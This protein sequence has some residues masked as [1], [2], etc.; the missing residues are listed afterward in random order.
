MSKDLTADSIA[1][2]MVVAMAQEKIE[3]ARALDANAL[4]LVKSWKD[5]RDSM[6]PRSASATEIVDLIRRTIEWIVN[7]NARPASRNAA[8]A[9]FLTA[10]SHS[11]TNAMLQGIQ[12]PEEIAAIRAAATAGKWL[13]R[14]LD[15]VGVKPSI[16]WMILPRSEEMMSAWWEA[17]Q[18]VVGLLYAKMLN[19]A[20]PE[21]PGALAADERQEVLAGIASHTT[22]IVD[23]LIIETLCDTLR[24][25]T[26]GLTLIT[27]LEE[28]GEADKPSLHELLGSSTVRWPK[29]SNASKAAGVPKKY[30][31][32]AAMTLRD[33][34]GYD[35]LPSRTVV[36]SRSALPAAR[37]S[38]ITAVFDTGATRSFVSPNVYDRLPGS[39]E[40]VAERRCPPLSRVALANGIVQLP[41]PISARWLHVRAAPDHPLVRVPVYVLDGAPVEV[42]FGV[43]AMSL[44]G[45][46][47]VHIE[48]D[49]SHSVELKLKPTSPAA[50]T[51]ATS[52]AVAPASVPPSP[53][54]VATP[55]PQPAPH[56]D[57]SEEELVG[58]AHGAPALFLFD[59]VD[60][61][62]V[63]IEAHGSEIYGPD[64]T[65]QISPEQ[66][67]A[68]HAIA[69]AAA[70]TPIR[71]GAAQ[72]QAI[73]AMLQPPVLAM[74]RPD[75]THPGRD[76]V[77][78]HNAP[79]Q[80][81]APPPTYKY[82]S[83]AEAFMDR[84]NQTDMPAPLR[85]RIAHEVTNVIKPTFISKDAPPQP[86]GPFRGA[87]FSL[88]VRRGTHLKGVDDS[89][90]P[91]SKE[92]YDFL[93]AQAETWVKLGVLEP[94]A[95]GET[96]VV[97]QPVV[98]AKRGKDDTVTGF[99]AAFDFRK[100]N[101]VL[102]QDKL[103]PEPVRKIAELAARAWRVTSLDATALFNQFELE[104]ESRYLTTVM[105]RPGAYFRFT[106]APF[107][108]SSILGFAQHALDEYIRQGDD[109]CRVYVDDIFL[110]H[111]L[112]GG[113]DIAAEQL[114]RVLRRCADRNL[115]LNADKA[116]LFQVKSIIVGHEVD[117]ETHTFRPRPARM[118]MLAE[119]P[120]PTT[121]RKLRRFLAMASAWARFLPGW[122]LH[123]PVLSRFAGTHRNG[124]L[125]WTAEADAVF[126]KLKQWIVEAARSREWDPTKQAF[127]YTDGCAT[128][129]AWAVTQEDD[130]GNQLLIDCGGRKTASH[131]R[132]LFPHE[133]EVLACREA[134]REAPLYI[135]RTP[136]PTIWRTDSRAAVML[137]QQKTA[138]KSNAVRR[139]LLEMQFGAL[140]EIRAEHIA[141]KSN[142]VDAL[143]RVYE[144]DDDHDAFAALR[145]RNTAP[146]V[147]M[148]GTVPSMDD[149]DVDGE[150]GELAESEVDD[151]D[152]V[153]TGT[154]E[155]A[156]ED[157]APA[158]P[159]LEA[160]SSDA[161]PVT[162]EDDET[163]SRRA[164]AVPVH[165]A[166]AE[167]VELTRREED[168]F[169]E[170]VACDA[171]LGAAWRD[172][173]R[174]WGLATV[175]DEAALT[176][177]LAKASREEYV[178]AA[179]VRRL[180]AMRDEYGRVFVH[181]GG[182][183]KL[184][185]PTSMLEPLVAA[186]HQALG[187]RAAD[188]VLRHLRQRFFSPALAD[189]AK[190]TCEACVTC[191]QLRARAPDGIV[192]RDDRF[193]GRFEHVHLDVAEF[194][195]EQRYCLVVVDRV[196]GAVEVAPMTTR[197]AAEVAEAFERIWL[198]R[199][200]A[201]LV[202]S[203]DNAAELVGDTMRELGVRCG[204]AIDPVAPRNPQANGVVE[205]AVRG[206][207]RAIRAL[208]PLGGDW[209]AVLPKA[210]WSMVAAV[211]TTRGVSPLMLTTG[212]TA[213]VAGTA[214]Q[215]NGEAA[216]PADVVA[217][218]V[219]KVAAWRADAVR[220]STA[221]ATAQANASRDKV[222]DRVRRATEKAAGGKVAQFAVGDIV[223]VENNAAVQ[224][225]KFDNR[226]RRDGP[227]EIVE[228][229]ADRLRARV[230]VW[231]T[232]APRMGWV[233]FHRLSHARGD[234]ATLLAASS[235]AEDTGKH[236]EHAEHRVMAPATAGA[237]ENSTAVKPAVRVP[238]PAV[239]TKKW[240]IRVPS[241]VGMVLDIVH[242]HNGSEMLVDASPDGSGPIITVRAD[243]MPKEVV[244]A[245]RKAKRAMSRRLR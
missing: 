171:V 23:K 186:A 134:T 41:A 17:N 107:G 146:A 75:Y 104:E 230:V 145:Y 136:I 11:V 86:Y 149:A 220:A 21:L 226:W 54:V 70:H 243:D 180:G 232:R 144:D 172:E 127:L 38:S 9:S 219:R 142:P 147:M 118:Q 95:R 114:L 214:Q 242:T 33:S 231:T 109:D 179:S 84:L 207:K 4:A 40:L 29:N 187:H 200:P 193:R 93:Q 151:E 103:A 209:R 197:T 111:S 87:V 28:V 198:C 112:D 195:G 183:R 203:C 105:I 53:P 199:Y 7:V 67:M 30:I 77:L 27:R 71:D 36:L 156:S 31:E 128:G 117:C 165:T 10:T 204:F 222:A 216:P 110:F 35:A 6:T 37:A 46:A 154:P 25:D 163:P 143:S 244:A 126:I 66:V 125:E 228:V 176:R 245:A 121:A 24:R 92:K 106:R 124:R 238:P 233:S 170:A 174:S 42:A 59:G 153:D 181:D 39:E 88:K 177:E 26:D 223:W 48:A 160:P 158:T 159:E 78:D 50:P 101:A 97:S 190:R 94:V 168:V 96:F 221:A 60:G 73:S 189:A 51:S 18:P 227:W 89:W 63:M 90:R 129:I 64:C 155:T 13:Y 132:K 44:M 166:E 83:G 120:R 241:D 43:D 161:S 234:R 157:A 1:K 113:W 58:G 192:G 205:V 239:K 47:A 79:V 49:L 45:G 62:V 196:T 80:P 122:S 135:V 108:L 85:D 56:A 150:A 2:A 175:R 16:S 218:G 237:V 115:A 162:S 123:Q 98:V 116:D 217:G 19:Y 5:V 14:L 72:A 57:M 191:Q 169:V 55:T 133:L 210:R 208:T 206:L 61:E 8:W 141:G 32:A 235:T 211:S 178:G 213:V 224:A 74:F 82:A 215:V 102:E 182:V 236:A 173:R 52:S 184:L 65:L 140:A 99:R 167:D 91:M 119:F 240:P 225:T 22:H 202:L 194:D 229:Q 137:R 69:Q 12:V 20:M 212:A 68:L 100:L 34:A 148:F 201:P 185:V 3:K 76:V 164:A 81:S 131:E 139:W 130:H 152:V 138:P 188:G 15:L